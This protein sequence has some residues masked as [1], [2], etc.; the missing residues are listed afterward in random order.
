MHFPLTR[1]LSFAESMVFS[2]KTS[3][4][5]PCSDKTGEKGVFP[6]DLKHELVLH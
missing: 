6:Y 4:A 3:S 1:V 5:N 2:H